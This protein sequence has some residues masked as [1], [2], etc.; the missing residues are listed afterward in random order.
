M[1]TVSRVR[2]PTW[3]SRRLPTS[4]PLKARWQMQCY[5]EC[6]LRFAPS[7]ARAP[8]KCAVHAALS[9]LPMKSAPMEPPP[10]SDAFEPFPGRTGTLGQQLQAPSHV[11]YPTEVFHR[12]DSAINKRFLSQP[13]TTGQL[14]ARLYSNAW[15]LFATGQQPAPRAHPEGAMHEAQARHVLK[16]AKAPPATMSAPI[17]KER[18]AEPPI[19]PGKQPPLRK[20]VVPP[21]LRI[22]RPPGENAARLLGGSTGRE[23]AGVGGA[24]ARRPPAPDTAHRRRCRCVR[25]HAPSCTWHCWVVVRFLSLS[26]SSRRTA[27]ARIEACH[28]RTRPD[29]YIS[30]RFDHVPVGRPP[31]APPDSKSRSLFYRSLFKTC[32]NPCT[33]ERSRRF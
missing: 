12:K 1:R 10:I 29:V 14:T 24:G 28:R 30:T 27:L 23:G 22:E 33:L 9:P 31:P 20:N 25:F 21:N 5:L 19:S 32:V 6:A 18:C 15:W 13:E 11:A 7:G 16:N 3:F 4:N 17:V 26:L 2:N 8:A